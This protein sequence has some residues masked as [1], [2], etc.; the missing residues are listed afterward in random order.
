M[1]NSLPALRAGRPLL[2]SSDAMAALRLL[3]SSA[4]ERAHYI[5]SDGMRGVDLYLIDDEALEVARTEV[6]LHFRRADDPS[7]PQG[8]R[9]M[10]QGFQTLFNEALGVAA[11]APCLVLI[12][13]SEVG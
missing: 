7:A 9:D 11:A 4:L 1:P 8:W 10:L 13:G 12:V 2:V 6:Q 3:A 5:S